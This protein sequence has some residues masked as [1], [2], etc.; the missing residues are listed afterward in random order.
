[1]IATRNC[2]PLA[3]SC[4]GEVSKESAGQQIHVCGKGVRK[5]SGGK[6]ILVESSIL[7]AKWTIARAPYIIDVLLWWDLFIFQFKPHPILTFQVTSS[8]SALVL[9]PTHHWSHENE[10]IT[11]PTLWRKKIR[12]KEIIEQNCCKI[13]TWT[14][15]VKPWGRREGLNLVFHIPAWETV[16]VKEGKGL[17]SITLLC[18]FN[19]LHSQQFFSLLII[20][21]KI[22]IGSRRD[23]EN[24]SAFN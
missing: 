18:P 14:S 16:E 24:R 22:M 19:P 13:S 10:C 17:V 15:T 6:G 2:Y 5:V 8:V 3:T 21:F 4:Q 1:M 11:H 23:Q 7:T 9:Q 12:P 20:H